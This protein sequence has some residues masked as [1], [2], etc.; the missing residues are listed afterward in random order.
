MTRDIFFYCNYITAS[1]AGASSSRKT[2]MCLR[3]STGEPQKIF[4]VPEYF[5]YAERL[6][7]LGLFSWRKEAPEDLTAAF[8]HIKGAYK[9][10]EN[11]FK[12]KEGGFRLDMRKM[13]CQHCLAIAKTLVR[14]QY[15]SSHKW[16]VH[17]VGCCGECKLH[18]S[19]NN[20]FQPKPFYESVILELMKNC[21][22]TSSD[23]KKLSEVLT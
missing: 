5:S 3:G 20:P 15:L 9:T 13:Q 16:R 23:T 22:F 10:R 14:H 21:Y 11:D 17:Y 2:W 1:S 8:Q 6:R 12:L 19:R 4:R 7:Q 18:P